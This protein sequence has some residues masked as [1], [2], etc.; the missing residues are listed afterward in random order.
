MPSPTRIGPDVALPN[1]R[2]KQTVIRHA[3]SLPRPDR[4]A[5]V[6]ALERGMAREC[7]AK[8]EGAPPLLHEH[9]AQITQIFGARGSRPRALAPR[10]SAFWS[11][12][13]V[14][15]LAALQVE[16]LTIRAISCSCTFGAARK[17][18]S[19]AVPS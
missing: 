8:E 12:G 6:R 11:A 16:D 9:I 13:H 2:L 18:H 19:A 5:R 17:T 7:G 10:S 14:S 1:A 4:D 15:E 3:T